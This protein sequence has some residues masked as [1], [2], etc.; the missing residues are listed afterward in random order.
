M[1]ETSI[2]CPDVTKEGRTFAKALGGSGKP[3]FFFKMKNSGGGS[4]DYDNN[5]NTEVDGELSGIIT[6]LEIEKEE[7][8]SLSSSVGSEMFLYVGGESPWNIRINGY[9]FDI[10]KSNDFKGFNDVTNWYSNENVA[11]TGRYCELTIGSQVFRGYLIKYRIN[12]IF[13]DSLNLFRFSFIF[14]AVKI[15]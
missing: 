8:V 12:S 13:K 14:I 4:K 7:N 10:C 3:F 5:R 6:D 15:K 1:G 2:Y 11:Q 9:A